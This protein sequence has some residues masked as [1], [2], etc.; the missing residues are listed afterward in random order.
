VR[1]DQLG[2]PFEGSFPRTNL[3]LRPVWYKQIVDIYEEKNLSFR[4]GEN[5]LSF[6]QLHFYFHTW[7][8]QWTLVNFWHINQF[9]SA[10]M[11]RL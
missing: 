6:L 5:Q 11:W 7:L 10:A 2:D 8:C 4:V 3:E 9:E 1:A